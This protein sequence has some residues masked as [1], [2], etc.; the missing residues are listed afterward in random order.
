MTKLQNEVVSAIRQRTEI[1]EQLKDD[2]SLLLSDTSKLIDQNVIA[3]SAAHIEHI[4]YFQFSRNHDIKKNFLFY[5]KIPELNNS[6]FKWLDELTAT[7]LAQG[8]KG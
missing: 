7:K 6:F 4:E 3:A 5:Q 2:Q 8:T 1:F